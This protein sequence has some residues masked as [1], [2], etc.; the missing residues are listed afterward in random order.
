M[1]I[2]VFGATGH[3]GR[4]TIDALLRRGTD[5]STIR[6]LGRNQERLDALAAAGL[7]TAVIDL[8]DPSTLAAPLTGVHEA[9]L[10]SGSEVGRRVDQHGN[11]IRAAVDAGVRRVVYTSVVNADTSTLALAPE[12]VATEQ[13]LADSGL[14]T[15]ILRNGWYTE[16]YQPDFEQAR[17][18]GVLANSVGPAA[19]IASAAR[20]DFAEAAAVVLTGDG[21]DGAVYELT[22]DPAWTWPEFAAAASTALGAPIEY[23]EIPADEERSGLVAAGLPPETAEFVS[24][25]SIATRDGQLSTVTGDLARLI[26]RPTAGL[27]E[28]LNTWV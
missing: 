14:V 3:L 6:A 28:V 20:A 2:A 17:A 18:T 27:A 21:H 26:G 11:A 5:P 15:T 23:R 9:L 16:N 10:I 19:R 22:G 12:H 4:L 25:L 13:L 1:T 8:N 24:G 7:E